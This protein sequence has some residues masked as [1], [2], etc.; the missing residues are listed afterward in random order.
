MRTIMAH[1]LKLRYQPHKATRSWDATISVQRSELREVLDDNP[2]LRRYLP[3]I[4][5]QAYKLA[6]VVAMADTGLDLSQFPAQC[7]FTVEEVLG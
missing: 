4:L 2:S 5:P 6:R 3:D 7:L 1:L